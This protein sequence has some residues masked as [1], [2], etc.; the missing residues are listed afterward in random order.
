MGIV[1]WL[2]WGLVG[3]IGGYMAGRLLNE[4]E[5]TVVLVILGIIG[6]LAGGRLMMI[7]EFLR[8]DQLELVS[9]FTAAGGCA[10]FLWPAVVA[11]RRRK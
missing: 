2:V 10:L 6:A 8:P 7:F 4:G 3:L 1:I 5:N 9:L 11:M